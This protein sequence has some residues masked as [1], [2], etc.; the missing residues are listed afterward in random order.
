MGEARKYKA[1]LLHYDVPLHRRHQIIPFVLETSGSMGTSATKFLNR[2]MAVHPKSS[3]S[4]EGLL[5]GR[6]KERMAADVHKHTTH[7]LSAR[8]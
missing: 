8:N 1:V 4:S 2:M 5:L 6:L 3:P 7:T